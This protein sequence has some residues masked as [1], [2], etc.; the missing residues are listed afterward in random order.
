MKLQVKSAKWTKE[1]KS[2]IQETPNLS[3]NANRNRDNKRKLLLRGRMDGRTDV[4]REGGVLTCHARELK[5]SR[6]SQKKIS[7]LRCEF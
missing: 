5:L 2:C 7:A 6:N 4:L 1:K 3:T